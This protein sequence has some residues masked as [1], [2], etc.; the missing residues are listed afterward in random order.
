M[1]NQNHHFHFIG[2]GGIGMS[3]IAKIL[4]LQGYTISGC[5][6]NISQRTIKE[7][8]QLGCTITQG[9]NQSLCRDQTITTVVHSTA[10]EP[11]NPELAAARERNT[12]IV[13][14]SHMLARIMA[15]GTSIGVTGAHGKT[16][17]TAM[18]GH[19]LT[20]AAYQ[21]TI[22]VGGHIHAWASNAHYASDQYI[23]AEVDE[24]DRSF[25]NITPT[26]AVVTNVDLEHLE[27]YAD[28]D[29]IYTSFT[30]FLTTLPAQSTRIVGA[31]DPYL[32]QISNKIPCITFGLQEHNH[33]QA[34]TINLTAIGSSS[35]LQDTRR[36]Q[37][38][39]TLL[40]PV[41]GIHNILNALAAIA[42]AQHLGI[43]L[44]TSIN[45]LTTFE[46]VDRRF[47]YKG[48][49]ATQTP[50]FDDYAHHPNEIMHTLAITRARTQGKVIA[51]WQP[52]R[53][54][55]TAALWNQFIQMFLRSTLTAEDRLI[56]TDIYPG[57]NEK[58]ITT[59]HA[60]DLAQAITNSNPSFQVLYLPWDPTFATMRN[61]I[62]QEAGPDDTIVTIGAGSITQFA[63][64]MV[65]YYRP[66]PS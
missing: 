60:R 4:R 34:H 15:R 59:I 3:G 40:L 11:T 1:S 9:H 63:Q 49:T 45:A 31:D 6:T 48:M 42:S 50:L 2:I 29:D 24:S 32:Q 36:N 5:D 37:V 43:P 52:H 57:P 58:P 7:L 8:T 66:T 44:Q 21:P 33:L 55:R 56:I 28:I 22:I 61:A 20:Y 12:T 38:M 14:R 19:I 64:H 47:T 62:E 46:S 10:I 30:S 39:G 25:L 18:I 54:I 51:C 41:P 16:T 27:T 65:S 26:I 35:I 13:H 53:Y 17:T 23:V